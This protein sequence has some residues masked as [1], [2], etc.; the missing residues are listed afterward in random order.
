MKAIIIDDEPK[1][2]SLLEKYLAHFP[3]IELAATFRNGLKAL[4]FLQAEPVDLI[5][6]DINMPHITG[7]SL[8]RLL[9]GK[10]QVIFTTAY[11]EYA[12]ESYE[13]SAADYL[14]KPITFERFT[15]A[16]LKVLPKETAVASVSA[17]DHSILIKSGSKTYKVKAD[18]I[19]YLEKDHNYM[20]YHLA[21]KRIMARESTTEA[22]E[23]LP[24]QFV[25][26]HKSYII[27]LDKMAF[28]DKQE[29]SVM[30]RLLSLGGS[31]RDAFLARIK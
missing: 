5:F 6:M 16:I 29:V 22:L 2:I 7:V 26:I 14:L 20:V 27:N 25:Q 31:Y 13:L 9:E 28:F 24:D 21:D 11:A 19:A 8:A 18:E 10:A 1:A 15:K 4:P 3:E 17:T 30:G 12:V 23:K